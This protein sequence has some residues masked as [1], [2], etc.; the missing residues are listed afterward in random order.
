MN[1]SDLLLAILFFISLG[2]ST[3][4]ISRWKT[5]WEKEK[6]L[7]LQEQKMREEEVEEEETDTE[8]DYLEDFLPAED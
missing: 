5:E 7:L 2:L 4:Q 3:I 6:A 8:E 1:V